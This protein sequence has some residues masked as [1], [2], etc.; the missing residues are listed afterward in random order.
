MPGLAERLFNS[1]L[2]QFGRFETADY[3]P[4]ALNLDVLPSYP[5]ALRLLASSVGELVA[6]TR[7]D[8]FLCSEDSISLGVASSL[9]T[10]IPL[11]YSRGANTTSPFDLVGAYDI[12]HPTAL[13]TN[14]IPTKPD[15]GSIITNA[16]RVG[17][18]VN[19]W[20]AIIDLQISRQPDDLPTRSLLRLSDAVAD[21]LHDQTLPV[22]QA[23]AVSE[24][25]S[26]HNREFNPLHPDSA[27]P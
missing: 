21:L 22:G 13:L 27:A 1:G 23:Q 26:R 25:I 17:L 9:H 12:G 7:I 24:W 18:E 11:V 20:I 14:T 5:D 16:R 3:R 6:N 8:R 2:L 15:I 4:F 10:G 19:L